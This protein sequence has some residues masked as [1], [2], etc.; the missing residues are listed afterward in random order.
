MLEDVLG[1]EVFHFAYPFGSW[2]PIARDAVIEA[3]Y[4]GACSTMSGL[5]RKGEDLFL[6]RRSEIKGNDAPWQFRLKLSFGTNDMPP[7]SDL[8]RILRQIKER[9]I[10]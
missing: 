9:I 2:S 3:G 8:R 5:N 1:R 4:K 10:M 7:T 6:L